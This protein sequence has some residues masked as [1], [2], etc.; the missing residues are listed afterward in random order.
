MYSCERFHT[1]WQYLNEFLVK[2]QKLRWLKNR[3]HQ[4]PS[5]QITFSNQYLQW[6]QFTK[7]SLVY[8]LTI[9]LFYILKG[10][11]IALRSLHCMAPVFFLLY[12]GL[13]I[14]QHLFGTPLL[15]DFNL[16][17]RKHNIHINENNTP[18]HNANHTKFSTTTKKLL[19]DVRRE[20]I[21]QLYT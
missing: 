18:S 3:T 2:T 9:V 4:T 11:L 6:K 5:V 20:K 8:K 14:N 15:F 10:Y 16:F 7:H 21:N 12:F 13:S 17:N 1:F 19:C